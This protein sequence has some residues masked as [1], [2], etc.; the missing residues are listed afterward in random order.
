MYV[1]SNNKET[2]ELSN[3]QISCLAKIPRYTAQNNA[4]DVLIV[5][6]ESGSIYFID[7]QAYTVLRHVVISSVP[8]K[9][10]AIGKFFNLSYSLDK[11]YIDYVYD[12][13][14]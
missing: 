11:L 8:V 13:S 1:L 5:G 9:F 7:S 6:T 14:F 3:I 10:L 4:V 12:L 2:I